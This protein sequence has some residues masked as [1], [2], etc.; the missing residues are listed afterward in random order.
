MQAS[1]GERRWLL[2]QLADR[3][4]GRFAL[5]SGDYHVSWAGTLCRDGRPLG[6]VVVAPPF[7]APL[8]YANALPEDLWLDER[9]ALD[10]GRALTLQGTGPVRRG[11]GYGVLRLQRAADGSWRVGLGAELADL[12]AGV[13]GAQAVTWA[14]V[15]LPVPVRPPAP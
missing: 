9:I 10:D 4:P 1:E 7:Y 3:V 2:Q 5:V 14:E 8:T 6:A 12:D 15:E 11:S 13:G